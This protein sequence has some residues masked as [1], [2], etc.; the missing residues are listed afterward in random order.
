MSA[1]FHAFGK[2]EFEICYYKNI[3]DNYDYI[4][5]FILNLLFLNISKRLVVQNTTL[6]MGQKRRL[7]GS[8]GQKSLQCNPSLVMILK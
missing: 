2:Y 1:L 8:A 3:D 4:I 6:L 5:L 7:E